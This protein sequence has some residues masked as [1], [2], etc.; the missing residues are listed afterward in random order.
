MAAMEDPLDIESLIM[1]GACT[2]FVDGAFNSSL[3]F[4]PQ[5]VSNDYHQGKKVLSAL[6][7]EL[8]RCSSFMFSV[9]F[10]TESGV[11]PLLQVFKELERRGVP[12]RILTTDYLTFSDPKALRKL[13]GLS[14]I[15]M[16]LYQTGTSNSGFHTKGYLFDYP[17]ASSKVLIGSS[18]MTD[19]ALTTNREWNLEL[20]STK[21]GGLLRD[22]RS[23][24]QTLWDEATPIDDV[25]ATYER[26]YREKQQ[27]LAAQPLVTIDQ[28]KL[29]PNAMQTAFVDNLDRMIRR[30]DD[31]AL[32][33][34]ATGTGKTYASAFALRHENPS[35]VLFL[36]HREQILKQSMASYRRVIGD[37]RSYGLLSSNA[38][39]YDSDYLFATMQTMS[40]DD[41]LHRFDPRA[42]SAIVID[43]V[44]RAGA[45]SYEKILDYFKADLYLGMTASP[46]RPDGF[47][48]YKLFDNNIACEI[49]LQQALEENLLC[50]FHYFGITDLMV[51]GRMVDDKT[52]LSDFAYLTS[53]ERVSRI[54]EQAD[55]YGYSG[56][57]VKG[58]IFCSRQDEA[59]E[60]SNLFNE[61]GFR[62]IALTGGDSQDDREEAIERLIADPDDK[63]FENRLDYIFT[64]DI[65]NEGVDIPQVNQ[66]IMLRPT[67]SPIVFVQQLGRGLRK[68]DG[69][70]FVVI[71]DFIGNYANNFMIP[72]ALSGDR[73]YNKDTI[74]KY[75]MEGSRVIPGAS[76]VHFDEVARELIF[77]SIDN[78][79][80][81]LRMLREKYS[82]LRNKLGRVPSMV[83]FFDYGEIDP[84]L[85]AE[86]KRSY[87]EFL[88]A[89]EP[90]DSVRFTAGEL[91][92]FEY[93][94]SYIANGM[95]PHELL[96]LR[97]LASKGATS[98]ETLRDDLIT[99]GS[100][101]LDDDDYASA[102]RILDKEFINTQG[103]KKHYADMALIDIDGDR[104]DCS[105]DLKRML[106]EAGFR[107]AF[108]DIIEFGLRR[109]S[110]KYADS[111][112]GL[113]LYEK[114]TR[115]SVCRLLDW[116][117]DD[118]STM[119]GYRMK[120]GTC[121]I[122]V[123]YHKKEDISSSTQYEDVFDDQ[124]I[125][126][127]M[128]R[129]RLTLESPE[130]KKIINAGND[131][132]DLY[133]FVKKH[134]NEGED[135]YY[136]GPVTPVRWEP[137]TIRDDKGKDLNIVN[138]KLKM[139]HPV[140]DDIYS[141]FKDEVAL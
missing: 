6:E 4:Q 138:F 53:D 14:N 11:T 100:A 62:T 96:M 51:D 43:E 13:A 5:F 75:V 139:E 73:T 97:E 30:G 91:L 27:M 22:V 58:L 127:W 141:Y 48:V 1:Q 9:A 124:R 3:A 93:I 77:R 55:Y 54:I 83:D 64:V 140:R 67:Q 31:K 125:F 38:H 92:V 71:L 103:E 37:G 47:D 79:S 80:I 95:R 135:F 52:A 49:R 2:A 59:R 10:I 134:D 128:T 99:Y 109:N 72:L 39:D 74:R 121:P 21:Q 69:R 45:H 84:L 133:L 35:R 60:L 85:F 56:D 36:A 126:S 116:Q 20:V 108:L 81:T 106:S 57:R 87:P 110:R 32:L 40:K 19:S 111:Q 118:S 105:L 132:V 94:S 65:F 130:V 23:E 70:E 28:M 24:F 44:H 136:M 15:E 114:Y 88:M 120:Y 137:K 76:S 63:D 41:V 131:G 129:S 26:I 104:I 102:I 46:D 86:K 34:S 123:T 66:V 90:G 18:N 61:R 101:S 12:G 82:L 89:C 33:I 122:F 42:F 113:T 50:P 7:A 107:S 16:R 112:D 17:D 78:S 25:I 8:S 117:Q 115:K 29:E 68:A 119:Y 98:R